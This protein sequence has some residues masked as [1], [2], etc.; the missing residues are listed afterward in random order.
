MKTYRR[1]N[2]RFITKEEARAI[3]L[4]PLRLALVSSTI[5][6]VICFSLYPDRIDW[7]R[8]AEARESTTDLCGLATVVC[9]GEAQ[10]E[11]EKAISAVSEALKR[12]VTD[13]T[14]KRIEYLHEKATEKSV[15]FFD[16]VATVYC[17]SQW[18]AVQ[19][20]IVKNG[21]RENS[22]GIFQISLEHH[23]ITRE[24]AMDA[25]FSIDWAMDNWNDATWYGYDRTETKDCTNGLHIEL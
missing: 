1:R 4:F 9:D 14:K 23:N 25:Y 16:A 22:W 11:V 7:V 12:E 17:E 20:M 19:S 5:I 13:E 18:Q 21:V 3:R 24:Q 2:G 15:P 10:Q 8:S 6:A